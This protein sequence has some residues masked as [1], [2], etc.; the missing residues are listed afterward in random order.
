MFASAVLDPETGIT[1]EYCDLIKE[2]KYRDVWTK[3]FAK[4]LDRLAQGKLGNKG[5]ETIFFISKLK[6]PN[7]RTVTYGQICVNYRPQK[8]D[9]YCTRLTIGGDRIEYPWD[10]STPTADLIT[11]KIHINSV[12]STV[13]AKFMTA[14]IKNFY[15][16][17][18]MECYEYMRLR[19]ETQTP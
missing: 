11:S 6:V 16:N 17:T 13:G 3:S 4:E 15:L 7:G 14:D 12:I 18:P 9:P 5:T 1:L 8:D 2:E 10:V 19:Y